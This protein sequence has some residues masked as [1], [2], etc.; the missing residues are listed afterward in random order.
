MNTREKIIIQDHEFEC[1]DDLVD[2]FKGTKNALFKGF[3]RSK[4]S[5][6][7]GA[8]FLLACVESKYIPDPGNKIRR[9]VE[10]ILTD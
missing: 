4:E 8:A 9:W 3:H 10:G 1:L 2:A 7:R 5:K 6:R